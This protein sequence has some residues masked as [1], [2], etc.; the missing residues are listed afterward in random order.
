MG[1]Y[2]FSARGAVERHV[3]IGA[4]N[5][6]GTVVR[7]GRVNQLKVEFI[8][9]KKRTVPLKIVAQIL[10]VV[11]RAV[12]QDAPL[13]IRCEGSFVEEFRAEQVFT[14]TVLADVAVH[15]Q[16]IQNAVHGPF[17]EAEASADLPER[18]FGIREI[19]AVQNIDSTLYGLNLFP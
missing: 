12:N 10:H 8:N 18:E 16:G 17:V 13:G 11:V 7:F 19:E 1:K 14:G 9:A 5:H 2:K 6:K 3:G 15:V 4:T